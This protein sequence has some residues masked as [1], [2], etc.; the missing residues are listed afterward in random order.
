MNIVWLENLLFTTDYRKLNIANNFI[1]KG[2]PLNIKQRRPILH[3]VLTN[4]TD[5][6]KANLV[7]VVAVPENFIQA[8]V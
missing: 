5:C 2:V 4:D 3:L 6:F 7:F 1:Y 8:I